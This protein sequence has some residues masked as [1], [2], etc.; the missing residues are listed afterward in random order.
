[1]VVPSLISMIMGTVFLISRPTGP[2]VDY[3]DNEGY[4]IPPVTE[5]SAQLPIPSSTD[6]AIRL[7]ENNPIYL[8]PHAKP[9]RCELSP[10]NLQTMSDEE[11]EAEF[12][13]FS[14]CLTRVWGP[15]IESAGYDVVRSEIIVYTG[16]VQS[17]CGKLPE[18][19]AAFC[20]AD[21]KIYFSSE[22]VDILP[23]KMQAYPYLAEAVL[24]HEY[25]HAV[26][27]VTGILMSGHYLAYYEA[28]SESEELLLYR[29]LEA[30]ADCFAGIFVGSVKSSVGLSNGD[31][32]NLKS[33]FKYIGSAD[34]E[35]TDHGTGNSRRRWFKTGVD[36]DKI[37]SC[38]TWTV[39]A[40][41]VP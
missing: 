6:E 23:P 35:V 39:P 13:K 12:N 36:S 28:V 21:Q 1:M 5:S 4:D 38:N 16:S 25:G 19:N 22:L 11:L 15:A 9:V 41:Q 2:G 27:A 26:Q 20:S 29:R 17:A 14:G 30:Q 3:Y 10:V 24:A 8:Q 7:A 40:D 32:E 31:I 37:S 18:Y 34:D 33:I